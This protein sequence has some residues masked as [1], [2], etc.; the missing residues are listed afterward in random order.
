[1]SA[2]LSGKVAIV[3][4]SGGAGLGRAGAR[5]FAAEG[6]KVVVLDV[7][8]EG[9]DET[10]RQIKDDGG[11]AIGIRTDV[12]QSADVEHM[13]EEAMSNYGQIDILWNNAA[14]LT[15]MF[16]PAEELSVDDWN[17]T[18]AVNLTGYFLCVKSVVP[19]MKK[20]RSGA[21][22]STAS[23]GAVTAVGPGLVHYAV[24]KAG[25][26][27][28]TRVL[29]AELGPFN[30][31]VNCLLGGGI[32]GPGGV[33]T[34]VFVPPDE[35]PF[36]EL[37]V[38]IPPTMPSTEATRWPTPGEFA[39]GALYLVDPASGPLTGVILP[40]DGGWTSRAFP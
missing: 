4:G 16:V 37:P 19:H 15:K 30:V 7:R 12:R 25:V 23:L 3:T 21:I 9:I 28:L 27:Q 29:A 38:V 33:W 32:R 35:S 36:G 14:I 18:L 1:V 10:L 13:V 22:V 2:R 17:E 34:E 6:A 8:D 20:R 24:S 39:A 11:E 5:L 31:R 26:V 40:V